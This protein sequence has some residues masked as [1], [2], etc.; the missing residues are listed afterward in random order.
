MEP[1]PFSSVRG[2]ARR[3]ACARRALGRGRLLGPP[4]GATPERGRLA[5]QIAPAWQ[6]LRRVIEELLVTW[7]WAECF[8]ALTLLLK[9]ALDELML[10]LWPKVAAA[11]GDPLLPLVAASLYEDCRWHDEVAQALARLVVA[12]HAS[13]RAVLLAARE[14]WQPAIDA[15]VATLARELLGPDAPDARIENLTRHRDHALR[16]LLGGT[17]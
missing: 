3:L 8:A 16:A 13:N 5:W 11:A 6:P 4:R 10:V 15:A 7:D 2:G 1:T 12:G 17:P 9:P 14:R